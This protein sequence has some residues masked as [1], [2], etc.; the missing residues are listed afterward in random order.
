MSNNILSK[1]IISVIVLIWALFSL[2]PMRD[3][4]FGEYLKSRHAVKPLEFE[5][6]LKKANERVAEHKSPSLFV[7]LTD[8]GKEEKI[9]Y[10]TFFPK[11]NV[12]DVKNLD[13]RNEI[14][15]RHLLQK[16]QGKIK[17]GLDLK[18]GA[19]F[20]LKV[21]DSTLVEKESYQKAQQLTKA[22]DIIDQ[23]V[24]SLGVAEP[25]IR[26][27]GNDSIE[28][29][30][31]G[32]NTQENPDALNSLKKPAKLTFHK[33]H[34]TLYP[35]TTPKGEEPVGYIPMAIETQDHKT[36][37]IHQTRYFIKKIPEMG[38]NMIKNAFANQGQYGEYE[39]IL[40][41]TD[42]GALRFGEITK[43]IADENNSSPYSSL[44]E[45]NPAKYGHLAIVLDGQLNSAPRVMTAITD[46]H[47]RI[48][49][50]FSQR[51]ALEL[52]SILNNP[53]EVELK[54]VEMYEV[55]PTLADDARNAS[56]K[57][58]ILGAGLVIL[59]MI[60][61]YRSAG[62]VAVISVIFNIL[63]IL[64]VMASL[65][66]T[67]T[68]PGIA[69]LVLT[70]GM[71]VDSNILIFE[72]MREELKVGKNLH[73]ALN[74]GFE[75]AFT[76]ILDANIT[77]LLTAVI[78]IWLGTGPIKGFGVTLSIGIGATLFCT[79]I[80]SRLILDVAVKYNLMRNILTYSFFKDSKFDFMK[81][82]KP[83]FIISW[84]IVIAG[85][86]GV[87]INRHH[88]YS[89]D[90]VGG[91]EVSLSFSEKI[92][93]QDI[94]KIA[95]EQQLGEV[96][97]SYQT[98][99]ASK[100]ESKEIL[101]I[102]TE[103]ARSESVV[104]ALKKAFPK[105]DFKVIGVTSIGG[106]VSKS[107]KTDALLAI[108]VAILGI[109]IYVGFRF[110]F[111]YGI[112]AV[113]S[114]VHDVLISIGIYVLLGGQFSAPMVAA[115]LMIIGYSINDT[116]VVFDRIR[117]EMILNPGMKLREVINLSIN[118]TLSRT[119]LTSATTF[120]AALALYVFATGVIHDFALVFMIG[121]IAGT[122]SSIFVA[123]PVF[124]WW[125]KGDRKHVET[126]ELKPKYEWDSGSTH[127]SDQTSF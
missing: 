84:L 36:G 105:S 124:F 110:E 59:F 56:I 43:A 77:T 19:S 35:D 54:L 31:P 123:A 85:I 53:L 48:S 21:D 29:Q 79:L 90:F 57:A 38:G 52:A 86:V 82:G 112:G 62:I 96:I 74:A 39:I 42:N 41:M 25:I 80:V 10:S 50:Q 72:R 87:I 65:R 27:R 8:I 88:I 9:D 122:F 11:I 51:E 99:L 78:L 16:S 95:S 7:A 20:T 119:I 64:A 66:S 70:V 89:I 61:Y 100:D 17:L 5:D 14:L 33:V 69:A 93:T 2:F 63:I 28:V 40:N 102:Q 75:K 108:A 60:F 15:L 45:N 118:R 37:E 23:R 46:G 103:Q 115:I 101:K 114:T 94:Y 76:T 24:N 3:T 34:R 98:L 116:I 91:D 111:G 73:N 12:A 44:S 117:E 55:G 126:K 58:S 18:G 67:L 22:I 32:L 97:P 92:P 81:Y 26:A 109:L 107:I 49:G 71:A 127:K 4:P 125:H 120:L 6:I 106:S 83:A 13:K 121:I 30:L 113:V 1:L 68:L 47:A 104:Q